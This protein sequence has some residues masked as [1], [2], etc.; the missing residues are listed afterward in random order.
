VP[1]TLD[2]EGEEGDIT[3]QLVSTILEQGHLCPLPLH[4]RP[5]YWEL[6]YTLRLTPLP[7][8]VRL[9]MSCHSAEVVR[10]EC[11]SSPQSFLIRICLYRHLSLPSTTQYLF[12]FVLS[13]AC[14][15]RSCGLIFHRAEGVQR[16][17][18]RLAASTVH[19]SPH[20]LTS[21]MAT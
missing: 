6:D 12:C 19:D 13:P 14:A 8:L 21:A 1:P 20:I 16:H 7:H 9:Q 5:I 2:R 10:I 18:S 17:Q 15:R 4:V 11:K 3:E